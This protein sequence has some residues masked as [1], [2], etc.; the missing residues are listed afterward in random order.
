MR[1]V[2]IFILL[3]MNIYPGYSVAD[4]SSDKCSF[5]FQGDTIKDSNNEISKLV[6]K[7][8]AGSAVKVCVG[9]NNAVAYYIA[10]EVLEKK[11]VCY[12][13]LTRVFKDLSGEQEWS[14]SPPKNMQHLATRD[15]Y[16]RA[17]ADAC[18]RQDHIDYI[19]TNGVSVG[20]FDIF[21]KSWK[22]IISSR[23]LFIESVRNITSID[24]H[25][26]DLKLL[27]SSLFEKSPQGKKLR[28]LKLDFIPRKTPHTPGYLLTVD[29]VTH[30]WIINFDIQDNNISIESISLIPE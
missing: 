16:M 25:A 20:V 29:D 2:L 30:S 15:V 9:A 28:I 13:Y 22:N 27:E 14:F 4:V 10:S 24:V 21:I 8:P 6:S 3:V 26:N 12:F 17:S 5:Y 11:E 7:L 23:K 19:Q 18:L 1:K